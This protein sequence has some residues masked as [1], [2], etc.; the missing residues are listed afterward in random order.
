MH[1]SDPGQDEGQPSALLLSCAHSL[2][3]L[4][5]SGVFSSIPPF[6]MP[7]YVI[8]THSGALLSD[9]VSL[10]FPMRREAVQWTWKVWLS[11]PDLSPF[12]RTMSFREFGILI[13]RLSADFL[14]AKGSYLHIISISSQNCSYTYYRQSWGFL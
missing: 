7:C 6:C 1:S 11:L 14:Y 3:F 8:S 4:E 13:T 10:L 12:W 9:N 2:T 5:S